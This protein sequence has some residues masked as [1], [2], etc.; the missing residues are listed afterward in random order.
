MSRPLYVLV[1]VCVIL[2]AGASPAL[3]A[4]PGKNGKIAFVSNR[5]GGDDDIWTMNPDGSDLVNLT[6]G[7]TGSDGVP[8]WSADGRKIVFASDRETQT[9]PRPPALRALTPRSSS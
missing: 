2:A 9:T 1:G 8:N 7:S 5:D 4:F 3:G 6:P